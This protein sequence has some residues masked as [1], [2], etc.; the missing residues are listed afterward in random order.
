MES[1]NNP[2]IDIWHKVFKKDEN[3]V[4]RK[5]AGEFFLVPIRG[6]LAD[7]QKIFTLNPVAEY[8]WQEIDN[9]KSLP[10]ICNGI[11]SAFHVKKDQAE[12]DV[13]EFVTELLA[14]DL[15]KE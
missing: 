15:I 14:E 12:S 9:Q 5:I 13:R 10:D 8:I 7:M 3:I 11:M 4:A 1:I 2:G 6:K